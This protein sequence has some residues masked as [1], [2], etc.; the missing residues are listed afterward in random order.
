MPHVPALINLKVEWK[1]QV[2]DQHTHL[3]SAYIM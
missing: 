2:A 1:R 3:Y